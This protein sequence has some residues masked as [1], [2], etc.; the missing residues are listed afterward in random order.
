M[1]PESKSAI[2]CRS[3]LTNCNQWHRNFRLRMST[4]AE[5]VASDDCLAMDEDINRHVYL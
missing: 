3:H 1:Q 4:A 5:L 2:C